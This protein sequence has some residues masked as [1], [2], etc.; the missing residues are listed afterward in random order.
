MRA[1]NSAVL[2]SPLWGGA[3]GGGGCKM[4]LAVPN[5]ATPLPNPPPQGG[6]EQTEFAATADA[7]SCSARTLS[8]ALYYLSVLCFLSTDP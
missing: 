3:G 5:R 4:Q 1:A 7:N 8:S 6:R 2:P